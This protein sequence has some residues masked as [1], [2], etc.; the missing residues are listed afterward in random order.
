MRDDMTDVEWLQSQ[1]SK[2]ARHAE[3]VRD[4]IPEQDGL[5]LTGTV[6]RLDRVREA[7]DEAWRT[8]QLVYDAALDRDRTLDANRTV[9]GAP[10]GSAG[11]V[12]DVLRAA[13]AGVRPEGSD[14]HSR[15]AGHADVAR[16]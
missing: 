5:T 11:V 6:M 7:L 14:N 1:I 8:L 13:A 12:A 15:A 10:S 4:D 16:R 3:A 9:G 2:A